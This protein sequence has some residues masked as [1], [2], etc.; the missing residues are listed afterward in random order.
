MAIAQNTYATDAGGEI[1]ALRL[2]LDRVE[3]EGLLVQ[4]DACMQIALF[5]L[6]RTAWRRLPDC[7]QTQP[8]QGLPGDQ[9]SLDLRQE[10][11]VAGQQARAQTRPGHHLD[12]EGDAGSLVGGGEL[13][14]QRN[15]DRRARQGH[16]RWEAN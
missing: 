11:T 12:A 9:G 1:S 10:G 8:P 7:H 4:A 6:H 14:W 3:I 13:A 16:P 2:P 15:G 5:P